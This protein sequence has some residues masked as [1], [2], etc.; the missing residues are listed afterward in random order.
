M[1]A[2]TASCP[3]LLIV[4]TAKLVRTLTFAW[5]ALERKKPVG[6]GIGAC[7]VSCDIFMSHDS[8]AFMCSITVC[9]CHVTAELLIIGWY[10]C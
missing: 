8:S 2:T 1:V 9:V 10:F 3:S 6:E 4:F 7:D 5:A